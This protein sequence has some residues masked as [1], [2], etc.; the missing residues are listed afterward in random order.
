MTEIPDVVK[1]AHQQDRFNASKL[2]ELEKCIFDPMYFICTYVKI[3][4]PTKGMVPFAIFPYQED[5]LNTFHNYKYVITMCGRQMGKTI[6]PYSIITYN[7]TK[8]KIKTLLKTGLKY[9]IVECLENI[10]LKLSK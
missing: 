3:Q 5:I 2:E 6:F 1:R 10:L 4:H 7:N 9:R 8:V